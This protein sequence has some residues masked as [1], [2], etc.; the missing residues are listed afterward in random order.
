MLLGWLCGCIKHSIR[1]QF[2]VPRA[3]SSEKWLWINFDSQQRF[4]L[5]HINCNGKCTKIRKFEYY[6]ADYF[7]VV[8]GKFL[9][10]IKLRQTRHQFQ[11]GNSFIF[12]FCLLNLKQREN[13]KSSFQIRV[14]LSDPNSQ[15]LNLSPM[16]STVSKKW[17]W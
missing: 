8:D 17:V 12:T 10:I 11:C 2:P 5:P 4:M 9:Y 1:F 14:F 13:F 6:M 16:N 15:F 7:K 3:H